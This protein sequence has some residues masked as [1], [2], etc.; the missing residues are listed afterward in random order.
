MLLTVLDDGC[1]N[2]HP[3]GRLRA[4]EQELEA[5]MGLSFGCRRCQR[6][7]TKRRKTVRGVMVRVC[8]EHEEWLGRAE[9][10]WLRPAR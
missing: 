10:V 2:L 1:W 7:D 4:E 9:A 8:A 6:R 3:G 5:G